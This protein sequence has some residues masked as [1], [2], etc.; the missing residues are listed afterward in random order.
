MIFH[1]WHFTRLHC[2]LLNTLH[3]DDDDEDNE[4][5]MTW[6]V[7]N[8]FFYLLKCD[9]FTLYAI[10]HFSFESSS[11]IWTTKSQV[12]LQLYVPY[13][14]VN[15]FSSRKHRNGRSH[16]RFNNWKGRGCS[17]GPKSRWNVATEAGTQEGLRAGSWAWPP[18]WHLGAGRF[19]GLSKSLFLITTNIK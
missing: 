1:Y 10:F 11:P 14:R 5:I 18:G 15:H 19:A 6:S 13:C 8:S 7:C 12:H 4:M 2:T 17:W 16:G 3:G 9:Q